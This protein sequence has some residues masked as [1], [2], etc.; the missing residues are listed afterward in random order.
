MPN[1]GRTPSDHHAVVSAPMRPRAEC[2]LPKWVLHSSEWRKEVSHAINDLDGIA[3]PFERIQR[4]QWLCEQA[5]QQA[6]LTKK[7]THQPEARLALGCRALWF[8]LH[9]N[10]D[11][12]RTI[13]GDLDLDLPSSDATLC[14]HLTQLVT[15]LWLV[16]REAE[17]A[18]DTEESQADPATAQRMTVLRSLYVAWKGQSV[19][20]I[21]GHITLADG[22]IICDADQIVGELTRHWQGVFE[23]PDAFDEELQDRLCR[24]ITRKDWPNFRMW[25]VFLPRVGKW[26]ADAG[27]KWLLEAA[28]KRVSR[29][30]ACRPTSFAFLSLRR[31]SALRTPAHLR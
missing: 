21:I 20:K 10:V 14:T 6:K 1:R 23:R 3:D 7:D 4:F 26:L 13:C 2:K 28:M 22:S 19:R 9:G 15:D 5:A 24:H 27:N 25:R 16:V 18:T 29:N 17:L 11:T 8:L 30:S 31:N 12:C